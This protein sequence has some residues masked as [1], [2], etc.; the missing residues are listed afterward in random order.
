MSL[1]ATAI[2]QVLTFAPNTVLGARYH[3]YALPCLL[4]QTQ[5]RGRNTANPPISHTSTCTRKHTQA[6]SSTQKRVPPRPPPAV[7]A[8]TLRR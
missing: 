1:A 7:P 4:E 5:R 2:A 3:L 6:N 8:P